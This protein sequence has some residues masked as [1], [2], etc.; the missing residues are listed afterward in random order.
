[1]ASTRTFIAVP[2]NDG[3]LSQAQAVIQSLRVLTDNVRW[4][5]PDNLHWTLQFLGEVTDEDIYPICREVSR[6][7]SDLEPYALE[8]HGVSAFPSI[9]KPRTVWLGAGQGSDALCQLQDGI[10]ERMARLGFRPERRRFTPHLTIGRVQQGSHG[11]D[12]LSARLTELADLDCGR[13]EVDEVL[14]FGSELTR[15]GP[16]YHVLGRSPL[17]G[18]A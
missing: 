11:G 14:V 10:E 5:A 13:M 12:A 4:V 8:A 7:V 18:G 16:M 15:E 2:A 9:E 3:V 1:M 6:E 17:T